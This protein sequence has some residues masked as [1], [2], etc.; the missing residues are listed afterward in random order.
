MTMMVNKCKEH[1]SKSN[2]K[3]NEL[4]MY[5]D[6]LNINMN[7]TQKKKKNQSLHRKENQDYTVHL[8]MQSKRRATVLANLSL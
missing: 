5:C 6:K 8:Y 1:K 7:F 2:I 3:V 4:Y